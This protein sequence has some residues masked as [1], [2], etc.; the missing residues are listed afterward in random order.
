KIKKY[1]DEVVYEIY[2]SYWPD[3]LHQF[4][5]DIEE[6]RGAFK[7]KISEEVLDSLPCEVKASH[8]FP[9]NRKTFFG[10]NYL[11]DTAPIVTPILE[12]NSN[13]KFKVDYI[14]LLQEKYLLKEQI[15]SLW[16]LKENYLDK[17]KEFDCSS[18]WDDKS[19]PASSNFLLLI[20]RFMQ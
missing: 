11:V 12:Q 15:A 18:D 6:E 4:K 8:I 7:Y 9:R 20:E 5:E 19:I 17:D 14:L 10:G 3:E 2:W 1:D 13:N 16:A